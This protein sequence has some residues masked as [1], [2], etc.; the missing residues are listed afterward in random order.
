MKFTAVFYPEDAGGFSVRCV[1]IPG[2]ISQGESREE[3][4]TNV[5]EAIGLILDVRRDE[6]H[7]ESP[8]HEIHLVEVDEVA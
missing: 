5:K 6:L 2:A 7:T 8:R 1:E 3:A 4:L